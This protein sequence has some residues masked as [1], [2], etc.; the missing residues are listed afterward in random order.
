MHVPSP[1]P[2][3]TSERSPEP[4]ATDGQSY[5]LVAAPADLLEELQ[6]MMHV[7]RHA[8]NYLVSLRL[9]GDIESK[10]LVQPGRP[11]TM[12]FEEGVHEKLLFEVTVDPDRPAD[13]VRVTYRLSLQTGPEGLYQW[14]AERAACRL[15]QWSPVTAERTELAFEGP[16][17]P[18]TGQTTARQPL[19][20]SR[21]RWYEAVL[22]VLTKD[23]TH[24][25][26]V[27]Q[28]RSVQ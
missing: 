2:V 27:L 8:K 15:G 18:V 9:A 7:E 13:Q 26:P 17:S 11:G 22:R 1:M 4:S 25:D 24:V 23:R 3:K 10:L 28:E 14:Y 16:P 5:W 6:P 20:Q 19:R 21:P 12:H